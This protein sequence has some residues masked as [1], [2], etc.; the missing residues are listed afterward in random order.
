MNKY[1]DL[2]GVKPGA[3]QEEIKK[4]WKKQAL[5]W[6]PDRNKSEEAGRKIQEI[7]EAYEIL[8]GKKQ[9]PQQQSQGN[10]FR[11]PFNQSHFRMKARP[12]NL[13]VDLSVE[14]VYNGVKKKIVF[15][16]DRICGTCHGA[17]GETNTCPTCKGQGV[18]VAFNPRIGAQ[19]ITMCNTCG[20]NGQVRV[21]SCNTCGGR[22][23]TNTVESID[24]NFPKG[25]LSGV[26]FIVT[27]AGNDVAG[28]NRGDVF[29]T[30]NV[31]PHPIYE[32]D[33]LNIN[34]KE[35]VPFIDMVLGKDVE[36][37]SLGGKYKITIP[38]NCESN[39]VFRMKGLGLTDEETKING[40]LYIKLVPKI[41]KEVNQEEKEIL[42]KLRNSINFS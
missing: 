13:I 23:V 16:V 38:P 37:E 12:L 10:P 1:Y 32:L 17:G 28:A 11:N 42:E 35:E 9:A 7:N 6:H 29:F 41:P 27:N 4:A 3:T 21:K 39:K 40:D 14:E 26:K 18:F 36:I 31:L 8:S 30:V 2:L 20:G 24:M 33:G 19:T 22:G 25:T 5:E 34:K 15:N